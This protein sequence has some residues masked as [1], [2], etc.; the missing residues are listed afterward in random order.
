MR[1]PLVTA[2][3]ALA[4]GACTAAPPPAPEMPEPLAQH[5]QLQKGVG[6]WEGTL[7]MFMPDTPVQAVPAK[8]VVQPIGEF[9][10]QS[11][12]TCNFMGMDFVGTGCMGYDPYKERYVGTWIDN[13][14]TELAV[15]TGEMDLDGN[16]LVMR[17]TARDPDSGVPT[18][19]RIETTFQGDSYTSDFFHGAGSGTKMMTIEMKRVAAAHH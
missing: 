18:P 4:L 9:W 19:H 16:T 10:T 14:T 13:M 3:F 7:T 8:E 1:T 2:L 15:M 5:K 6:T 11:T 17:Y 12:F